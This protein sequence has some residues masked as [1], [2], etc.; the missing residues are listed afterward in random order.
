[1]SKCFFN[2]EEIGVGLGGVGWG[3]QSDLVS[4][5]IQQSLMSC[6]LSNV[7]IRLLG[8]LLMHV[9]VLTNTQDLKMENKNYDHSP[10]H[11]CR[12]IWSSVRATTLVRQRI[13]NGHPKVHLAANRK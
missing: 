13:Q 8:G 9:T 10:A 1:M 7:S 6:T 12:I 4:L 5:R 2:I 11:I 3:L